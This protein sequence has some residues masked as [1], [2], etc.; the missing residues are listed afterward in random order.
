MSTIGIPCWSWGGS[1]PG[2]WQ[3]EYLEWLARYHREG[4]AEQAPGWSCWIVE[5]AAW[6]QGERL[7]HV[8]RVLVDVM[9]GTRAEALRTHKLRVGQGTREDKREWSRLALTARLAAGM[10]LGE[11]AGQNGSEQEVSRERA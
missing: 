2:G 10:T 8:R 11:V 3:R 6:T 1:A 9:A 5:W 4:A 7:A